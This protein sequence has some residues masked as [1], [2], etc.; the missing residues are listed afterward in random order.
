M[1]ILE[2]YSA[3]NDYASSMNEAQAEDRKLGN[4]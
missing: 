1:K 2:N 3:F 4:I